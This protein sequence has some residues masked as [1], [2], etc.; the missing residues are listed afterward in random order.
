M[1]KTIGVTTAIAMLVPAVSMG[2]GAQTVAAASTQGTATKDE[3]VYVNVDAAGKTKQ[4]TVSDWLHD[5]TAGAVVVDQ[6]QLKDITN[7]KGNEKPQING[8]TVTWN[9]SGNDLYYQGKTDK[10]IPV[11][12]T[13]RY[14]LDGQP[15]SPTELAGKSGRFELKIS[16]QNH[17]GHQVAIGGE[18]RTVYTPFA[19]LA[20]LN[21]PAKHFSN[22][23][24][25]FGKVISDGSNQA[26][27]FIGF[28]G[29]KES[30]SMLDLSSANLP[31]ELDVT[32][33]AKDFTLG[34]VMMVATPVPDMDRL[35]S[36]GDLNDLSGKLNE[37]IDAGLQLKDATGTLNAGEKAFA[38]G[39]GQLFEG[40]NTAGASFDQ[41]VSGA[42]AL[43]S[44]VN[45]SQSGISSLIGG[46]QSLSNGAGQVSDGLGQLMGQFQ[47][48]AGHNSTLKDGLDGVNDGAQGLDAGLAEVEGQLSGL[49]DSQK[50]SQQLDTLIAGIG[51]LQ[52]GSENYSMLSNNV[53]YGI[54]GAN[55]QALTQT[56]ASALG[57]PADSATVKAAAAQA[58][59]NELDGLKSAADTAVGKY[60]ST[61]STDALNQA[62]EYINLYDVWNA[63]THAS[64]ES[65]F[66]SIL[67]S[68]TADQPSPYLY[69]YDASSLPPATQQAVAKLVGGINLQ[70][71][72]I[73][74]SQLAEGAKTIAE[75]VSSSKSSLQESLAGLPQLVGGIQQLKNG[76]D[77]LAAGTKALDA[78]TVSSGDPSN[79]TLYDAVAALA[80]GARQVSTGAQ[81]LAS[82]ASG[83]TQ[84]QSGVQS[85]THALGL[86]RG[87]LSSVQSGTSALHS[88]SQKLVDGTTALNTGM[89]QF[90]DQGLS[91][92]QN[93]NTDKMAQALA[94][95]DEMIQLADNCTN[96]TGT[97][98]GISS[99][100]KFVVKTDEI[101]TTA[102]SASGAA[103]HASAKS[104]GF[105]Q[106]VGNWFRN[107]FR[108]D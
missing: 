64:G 103:G 82:G 16:F 107:L 52:T 58:V 36:T 5:D 37:L 65:G 62:T 74:G 4:E 91:Q 1:M 55:A 6:S 88:N 75:S 90:W 78:Q 59:K 23:A 28:P 80:S 89:T 87:G 92:L 41:I 63:A 99:S 100:V 106:K 54:A 9:L 2:E 10:A 60:L 102:S 8:N 93:V 77:S 105:W 17:D 11:S 24:T 33:D 61:Q 69:T 3:S 97:G 83:L 79:P 56:L 15:V 26:V 49:P 18:T 34:P 35:K 31:E 84:L 13:L 32:A 101:K 71:V 70:N 73:A 43:D 94:V 47:T 72:G 14:Y 108:A 48:T 39:V 50:L 66:E 7:V 85:L 25:N 76:A 44:S 46:T 98:D 68:A 86:F 53:I 19:C 95:K 42:N 51:Q 20:A 45:G 22:V 104:Q 40:V 12:M 57:Q 27:S 30:F 21:L 29:L 81:T 67:K 96:F 38:D